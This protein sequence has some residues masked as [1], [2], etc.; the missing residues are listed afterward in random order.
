MAVPIMPSTLQGIIPP[1]VTPLADEDSLDE[2]GLAR[3]IDRVIAGGVDALFLLGTTGESPSLAMETKKQFIRLVCRMAARRLPVLVNVT[4][5][6]VSEV[7]N[8]ADYAAHAGAAAIVLGPPF[9]FPLTQEELASCFERL[10]PRL[11]LPVYLYNYPQVFKA[12]FGLETLVRL[13][14]FPEV[15]GLKDSSGDMEYFSAVRHLFPAGSGFGLYCGPEEQLAEAL[16]LG[17]DG[18]VCG[19]ANLFPSLY[20]GLFEAHARGDE[21]AIRELHETIMEVSRSIY[22]VSGGYAGTVRGIKCAL[23]A[24]GV[25]SGATAEPLGPL[26]PELSA[27]IA[28]SARTLEARLMA[29]AA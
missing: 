14:Q 7:L 23:A 6:A 24:L 29:R 10:I 19:G 17:A 26:S 21:R 16:Q 27:R 9:Y 25:S 3:L 28:A 8:L 12:S 18:G 22:G 11:P 13:R 15:L 2:P 4:V 20:T 1:L 5:T